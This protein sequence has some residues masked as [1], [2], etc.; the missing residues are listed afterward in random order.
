[1][2]VFFDGQTRMALCQRMA[3]RCVR[4]AHGHFFHTPATCCCTSVY[5]RIL[6]PAL[7][8]RQTSH[9]CLTT[10]WCLCVCPGVQGGEPTDDVMYEAPVDGAL[11][12]RPLSLHNETY[13]VPVDNTYGDGAIGSSSSSSSVTVTRAGARVPAVDLYDSTLTQSPSEPSLRQDSNC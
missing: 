13:E 2:N 12:Q 4:G 11:Q 5:V 9:V 10:F 1:M 3:H 6:S 8:A 7:H